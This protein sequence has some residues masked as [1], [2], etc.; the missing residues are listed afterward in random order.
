MSFI[1]I[2][3]FEPSRLRRLIDLAI[4]YLET[5]LAPQRRDVTS[6]AQ[7]QV[8]LTEL[9]DA[10][11]EIQTMSGYANPT[12]GPHDKARAILER[13]YSVAAREAQLT[14]EVT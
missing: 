12:T 14:L 4:D 9:E 6:L 7:F 5:Q 13:L 2:D 11:K 8:S 1:E 3:G 10:L